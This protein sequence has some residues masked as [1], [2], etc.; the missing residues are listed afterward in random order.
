MGVCWA[1][2]TQ[3]AKPFLGNRGNEDPAHG[4]LRL[5]PHV[6]SRHEKAGTKESQ[7]QQRRPRIHGVGGKEAGQKGEHPPKKVPRRRARIERSMVRAR[8]QSNEQ[9]QTRLHLGQTGGQAPPPRRS[10][11]TEESNHFPS[12]WGGNEADLFLKA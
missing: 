11:A 4:A 6:Y 10:A 2:E 8:L 1:R 5:K 9:R 7:T 3:S 12:S